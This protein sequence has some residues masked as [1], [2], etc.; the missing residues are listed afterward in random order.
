MSIDISLY[1]ESLDEGFM[2]L[3]ADC[4][5]TA[6]SEYKSRAEQLQADLETVTE[7]ELPEKPSLGCKVACILS[8]II[9]LEDQRQAGPMGIVYC[10]ALYNQC[11]N[12]CNS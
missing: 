1:E 5:E 10:Q 4:S 12:N 8:Y 2:D 11:V 6:L 7:Q 3:L 9:C